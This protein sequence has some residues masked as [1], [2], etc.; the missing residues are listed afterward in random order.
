MLAENADVTVA[1]KTPTPKMGR[2]FWYS[3]YGEA[4]QQIAE[5]YTPI[6]EDQG[7]SDPGVVLDNYLSEAEQRKHRREAMHDELV[8]LLDDGSIPAPRTP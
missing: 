7:S 4:V 8:T 6:A 2:R 3:L 5:R 1:G